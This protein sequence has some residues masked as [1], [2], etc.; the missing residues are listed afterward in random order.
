MEIYKELGFEAAHR[1]PKLPSGHKCSRLHG[2]SYRIRVYVKGPV[3]QDSGWVLDFADIKEACRPVIERLDHYYLNE[4]E[5]LENPTAENLARWIW[6]RLKLKM[7]LL[8]KIE[9]LET[10]TTGCI[11]AGEDELLPREDS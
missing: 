7:P 11:Y 6:P 1:L 9:I 8:A 3:G 10:C 5:G 2:H 4:I